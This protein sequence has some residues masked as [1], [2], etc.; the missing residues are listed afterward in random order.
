MIDI[1]V[2]IKGQELVKKAARALGKKVNDAKTVRRI[3]RPA[4]KPVREGIRS[5]TPKSKAPHY[6]YRKGKKV[7]E[8][9]PGHLQ[10]STQD[11]ANRKRS[12]KRV[13]AIYVGP[14]YTGKAGS[15]GVFGNT[16]RNVDA[17]YA[18]MVFGSALAFEKR[19]IDAGFNAARAAATTAI[20]VNAIDIIEK[21]GQ[22]AGFSR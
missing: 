11:I 4:V 21:E 6:Y 13:A 14:V 10:K 12:Y 3:V 2:D 22:K 15:G 19:V 5:K 7:A 17:Y 20:T 16:V 1:T 8:F 9:R 18:H